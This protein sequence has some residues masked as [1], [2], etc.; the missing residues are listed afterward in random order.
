MLDEARTIVWLKPEG[1]VVCW[2]DVTRGIRE[3]TRVPLANPVAVF[4]SVRR[5]IILA[6]ALEFDFDTCDPQQNDLTANRIMISYSAPIYARLTCSIFEGFDS[7]LIPIGEGKLLGD[8]E[9]TPMRYASELIRKDVSDP[10]IFAWKSLKMTNNRLAS[11]HRLQI[12]ACD[13]AKVAMM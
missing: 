6:D 10:N 3:E 11:S 5:P 8:A 13:P 2:A 4:M 7:I 12:R 9:N 1:S